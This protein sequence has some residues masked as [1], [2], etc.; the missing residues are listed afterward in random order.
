MTYLQRLTT[1]LTEGLSRVP[2]SFRRRQAEYLRNEQNEDGGFSGR[3]GG[4]D[5][6]YTGF[7]LRGLS[8]LDELTEATAEKAGHYLQTKLHESASVVEFYSLLYS[9]LLVQ[10]GGGGDVLVESSA[11]WPDRVAAVLESFRAPDGGYG[12]SQGAASGSTYHTFL[13][14]MTYELLGRP[15]PTTDKVIEFVESRQREDG[16]FVELKPM[17]RSGTNPTAAAIGTMQLIH[18]DAFDPDEHSEVA[19]FLSELQ[20]MEGG[21][22]ANT[23]IPVADL[24]STFTAGWTLE[25][26]G[27]LDTINTDAALRYA[28]SLEHPEGGFKGGV[29]DGNIVDDEL[30][31]DQVRDVEYTF[32]G[33]GVLALLEA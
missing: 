26:L 21:I 6:Y 5:L 11:D 1:R 22:C 7:A 9:C 29:W 30:T 10:L 4:S 13:V 27:Q 32:Y 24:L 28:K 19:D 16:G 8:V 31:P 3:E 17:R 14:G 2:E 23:R 20:S 25:Q 33:L 15:F 12:K 18:G